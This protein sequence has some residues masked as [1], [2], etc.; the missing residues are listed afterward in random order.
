MP[1]VQTLRYD[2]LTFGTLCRIGLILNLSLWLPIGV[3]FGVLSQFGLDTV[4]YNNAPITGWPAAAEALV[5]GVAFA[6]LGALV[7][8]VAAALSRLFGRLT[9]HRL[10]HVFVGPPEP[11]ASHGPMS[12]PVRERDDLELGL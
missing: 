1:A 4:K 3:L 10:L 11:L 7:T 2:Q 9:G 6:L 8:V 12:A 5:I